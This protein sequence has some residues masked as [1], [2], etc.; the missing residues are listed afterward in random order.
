MKKMTPLC[1]I[2]ACLIV[3]ATSPAAAIISEDFDGPLKATPGAADAFLGTGGSGFDIS[4]GGGNFGTWIYNGGNMGIDDPASGAGDGS[5]LSDDLD[6]TGLARPQDVRGSNGRA[7]SVV[8]ES[9]LFAD[10]VEYTVSFDVIGDSGG[11]D[12]G[13]YSLAEV[14][15]YDNTGSNY[16]QID[17]SK[18]GW[19]GG[20]VKPFEGLGSATV[21]FLSDYVSIAGEQAAS[22]SVPNSFSFTYDDTNSPDI[23]FAVGTFN[24]MYAIDNFTVIPEPSSFA[25]FAGVLGLGG[26]MIR[27]RR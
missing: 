7:I 9:S 27:R 6:T 10:G 23:A 20:S 19:G 12:S 17:G 22:G 2:S 25:L 24:N 14:Y 8:F 15:G 5:S 13:F 11:F 3:T 21:N 18:N 26:V 1:A 16:I 4:G